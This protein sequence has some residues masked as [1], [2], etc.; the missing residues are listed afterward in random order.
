MAT[1]RQLFS[2]ESSVLTC[3]L[4]AVASRGSEK[5]NC[6]CSNVEE[7]VKPSNIHAVTEWLREGGTREKTAVVI[8]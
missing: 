2:A 3:V 6:T 5:P 1:L 8:G 4:V 7:N